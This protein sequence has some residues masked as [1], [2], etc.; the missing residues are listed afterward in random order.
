M[1]WSSNPSLQRHYK[2]PLSDT[3]H[4][5]MRNAPFPFTH[6]NIPDRWIVSWHQQVKVKTQQEPQ[7]F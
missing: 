3:W 4:L 2:H 5:A 7:I 1:Y 6:M